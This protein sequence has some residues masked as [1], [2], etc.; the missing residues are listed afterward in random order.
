LVGPVVAPR[1]LS[2]AAAGK[3]AKV[4]SAVRASDIVNDRGCME[5]FLGRDFSFGEGWRCEE[6]AFGEYQKLRCREG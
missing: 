2:S 5:F 4:A 6:F 3:T 1:I